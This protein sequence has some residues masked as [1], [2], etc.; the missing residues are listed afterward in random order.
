MKN[1][2]KEN[3]ASWIVGITIAIIIMVTWQHT[4]VKASQYNQNQ[5][6]YYIELGDIALQKS[7]KQFGDIAKQSLATQAIAYYLR[8]NLEE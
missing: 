4:T 7:V 5:K 6:Q 1:D 2:R 3:I 8:A